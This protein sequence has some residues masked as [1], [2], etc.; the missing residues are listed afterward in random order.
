MILKL[1]KMNNTKTKQQEN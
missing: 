1:T